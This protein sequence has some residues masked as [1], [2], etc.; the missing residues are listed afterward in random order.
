MLY[1]SRIKDEI[2]FVDKNMC[3]ECGSTNILLD[4]KGS[5][6]YHT[7]IYEPL[8]KRF[9]MIKDIDLAFCGAQCATKNYEKGLD[10]DRK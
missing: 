10:F 8:G 5:V 9:K 2:C 1:Y 6:I 4:N 7:S 3:D